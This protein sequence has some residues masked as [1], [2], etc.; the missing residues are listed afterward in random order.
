M[1][2]VRNALS[3][4]HATSLSRWFLVTKQLKTGVALCY[5]VLC[6]KTGNTPGQ[7]A[8]SGRCRLMGEFPFLRLSRGTQQPQGHTNVSKSFHTCSPK[9]FL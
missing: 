6:C 8:Q 9:G 7:S 5:D 3:A 2:V 4:M 1:C